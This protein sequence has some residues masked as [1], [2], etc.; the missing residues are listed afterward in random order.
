MEQ[1]AKKD[2]IEKLILFGYII[3]SL[4]EEKSSL[5]T[6]SIELIDFISNDLIVKK[7]KVG[8]I[9]IAKNLNEFKKDYLKNHYSQ[10]TILGLKISLLKSKI[11]HQN[12]KKEIFYDFDVVNHILKN[13]SL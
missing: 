7:N 1:K 3:K 8:R 5:G 10:T 4:L 12:D 2:E 13:Y 11:L 9:C 6:K